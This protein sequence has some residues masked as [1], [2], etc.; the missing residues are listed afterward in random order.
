M[1]G[2]MKRPKAILLAVALTAAIGLASCGITALTTQPTCPAPPHRINRESY[3]KI[4][5]GMTPTQ[6]EEII[7]VP[8]GEHVSVKPDER[9]YGRAKVED[10]GYEYLGQGSYSI[11]GLFQLGLTDAAW[12]ADEGEIFVG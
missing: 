4:R 10:T 1:L 9:L 5:L 6:V 8:P 7:G 2:A 11:R 12:T 3:D